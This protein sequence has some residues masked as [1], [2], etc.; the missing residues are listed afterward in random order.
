MMDNTD[1]GEAKPDSQGVDV[2]YRFSPLE[3]R[4]PALLRIG[5]FGPSVLFLILAIVAIILSLV[6]SESRPP[7]S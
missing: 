2:E 1:Y 4:K 3:P 7:D 6:M 5:P